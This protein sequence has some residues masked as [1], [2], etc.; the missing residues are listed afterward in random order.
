MSAMIRKLSKPSFFISQATVM[1]EL[2][3]TTIGAE[4][5]T[6]FHPANGIFR[7]P[8]CNYKWLAKVFVANQKRRGTPSRRDS[9]RWLGGCA[10]NCVLVAQVIYRNRIT[11]ALAYPHPLSN[12]KLLHLFASRIMQRD[13]GSKFYELCWCGRPVIDQRE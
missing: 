9:F 11:S 3:K 10:R 6:I 13:D 2:R 5:A 4:A 8:G 7:A 12:W 1:Q